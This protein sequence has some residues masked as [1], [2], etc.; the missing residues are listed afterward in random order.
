VREAERTRFDADR[1]ARENSWRQAHNQPVLKS[2]EEIKDDGAAGIL[3]DE[4][5]QIAADYAL[6]S[7]PGSGPVQAKRAAP[8]TQ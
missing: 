1:L 7:Q 8:S 2:L 6:L 5:S 4:T 3:L